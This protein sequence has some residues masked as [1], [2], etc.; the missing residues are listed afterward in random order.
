[1]EKCRQLD[2]Q[3]EIYKTLK[4]L[5]KNKLAKKLQ[6]NMYTPLI[7][8]RCSKYLYKLLDIIFHF[9]VTISNSG[10]YVL[11]NLWHVRSSRDG[12]ERRAF[13]LIPDFRVHLVCKSCL[14]EATKTDDG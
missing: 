3:L 8:E 4:S 13:K 11:K 9:R 10:Q 7:V 6:M 12:H 5:Q 1:M 2:I 14:A